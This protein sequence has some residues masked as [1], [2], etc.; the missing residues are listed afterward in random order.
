MYE[1]L[2]SIINM[3]IYGNIR[4][5]NESLHYFSVVFNQM[6]WHALNMVLSYRPTWRLYGAMTAT[7]FSGTPAKD[8]FFR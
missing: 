5:R 4:M 8:N 6:L 1:N 3:K 2:Q 7:E